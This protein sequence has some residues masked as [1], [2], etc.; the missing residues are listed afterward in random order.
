MKNMKA[1][2]DDYCLILAGGIGSRLWPLSR[3]SKPKQFLDI[4]GVGRTQLQQTYDRFARFMDPSHIYV[5]T[6]IDYLPLIY[7]QLPQVDDEH[8]LEEPLRRGT[9]ASVAWGTVVISKVNSNA[10]VF[11]SPADQMI[12]GEEAF[13]ED[14]LTAL[15]FASRNPYIVVM[16]VNPTRPETEY[17]YIQ[18]SDDMPEENFYKVKSF[19]EKPE[20]QFA[21]MFIDDGGFLWNA[22]LFAF[23]V[24]VMLE[25]T[26]KLVPEYQLEI[27][28]MMADA[29]TADPKFLPTFFSVLPNLS[30]DLG[31]ME[32]S[33]NVFVRQCHFGWADLG[34]WATY[35]VEP[36]KNDNVA[37]DTKALLHGCWGNVIRLPKGRTA[38][39][40]GLTDYLVAEE[41]DVLL[42]CPKN[43]SIVRRNMNDAQLHLGIE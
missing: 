42:I 41:G 8:I 32:R 20:R 43:R 37:V 7:E 33:D 4:F 3:K 12:L 30:L 5:S 14:V 28:Q 24:K 6:N 16:G 10:N 38:I 23:N 35:R 40:E 39:I 17:G 25:A 29:E 36:D 15:N 31:I 2:N 18:L 27:P 1:S 11:V 34:T 13:Q 19:T 9:L 22:G 21:Q 26:Y